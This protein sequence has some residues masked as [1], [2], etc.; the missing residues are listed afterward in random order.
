MSPIS[1]SEI[2]RRFLTL[3]R[4]NLHHEFSVCTTDVENQ[5]QRKDQ[6]LGLIEINQITTNIKNSTVVLKSL[7]EIRK[8]Y[9]CT[10]TT[11]TSGSI[12]QT[13]L[14]NTDALKVLRRVFQDTTHQF[15][16]S[17]ETDLDQNLKTYAEKNPQSQKHVLSY[18]NQMRDGIAS[19][20]NVLLYRVSQRIVK[21]SPVS[22][23][24]Q[25]RTF[26][27]VN[28]I[29]DSKIDVE[30]KSILD[31]YLQTF[32]ISE[33]FDQTMRVFWT[34]MDPFINSLSTVHQLYQ[35]DTH[36]DEQRRQQNA[37]SQTQ[38][39]WIG[40]GIGVFILILLLVVWIT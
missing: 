31:V 1:K 10:P 28:N 14:V 7:A 36:L 32:E 25:V 22:A 9:L 40:I 38:I 2:E 30:T 35:A 20:M 6:E 17:I 15:L 18:F 29:R 34:Y 12:A 27:I 37:M 4:A 33:E 21:T 23:L 5:T 11:A 39:Q 8:H 16:S 26:V 24:Y 19:E 3:L 13:E